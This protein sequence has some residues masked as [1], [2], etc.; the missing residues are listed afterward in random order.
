M[1]TTY[2]DKM[3]KKGRL[4]PFIRENRLA[5]FFTF[6]IC[7][8]GEE[9]RFLRDN[10][11]SVEEDNPDRNLCWIDHFWSDQDKRNPKLSF[12]A[13]RGFKD[14]L[15]RTFPNVRKVRW[16]RWKNNKLTRWQ[17]CI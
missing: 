17:K 3:L 7:N 1:D 13:W 14:Y 5:G 12:Q 15:K 11:W 9:E 4:M 2:Y 8:E 6:Y 16:N 10:M